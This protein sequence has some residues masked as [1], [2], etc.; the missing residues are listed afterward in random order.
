MTRRP[1]HTAGCDLRPDLVD[2]D[3]IVELVDLRI[4]RRSA[5]LTGLIDQNEA[6]QFALTTRVAPQTDVGL[7]RHTASN[8]PP[9]SAH[10]QK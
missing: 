8:C 2:V 1:Q 10:T 7:L 5:D 6:E 3:E 9:V 4:E